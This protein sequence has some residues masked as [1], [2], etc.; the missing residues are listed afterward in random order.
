M[1]I[2]A[3]I[4]VA[5][6]LREIEF[7]TRL[8]ANFANADALAADDVASRAAERSLEIISECSRHIDDDLKAN[9][10]T[11]PWRDVAHIGN[12]IRH[13][14]FRVDTAV[15]FATVRDDLPPLREALMVI[16]KL[17]EQRRS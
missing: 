12:I 4:A 1:P 14:Y 2:P 15:I 10:P 16:R 17:L 9:Q 8:L 6:I 3:D 5:E 11:I 13:E 7:V